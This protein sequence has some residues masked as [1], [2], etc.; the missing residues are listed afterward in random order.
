MTKMFVN[1]PVENLNRSKAFFASL[2]FRFNPQFTNESAACMVV[3]EHNYVMLLGHETFRQFA[4]RPIP[5]ARETTGALVA[6]SCED[7]LAVDRMIEQAVAAGGRE[8]RPTQDLGFMYQRT[9]EDP[10]GH[11][12]EP[13]WMDPSHVQS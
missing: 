4:T 5:N 13:F 10:D 1:L 9:F 12:W 2:G 3:S 11:V 7:K 8:P 6:I